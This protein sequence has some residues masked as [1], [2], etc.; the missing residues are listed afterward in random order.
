MKLILR[1]G[2]WFGL[3]LFLVLLPL[4]TAALFRP[5]R[6]SPSIQA[7]IAVAAG[8]VGYTLMAL[9]FAL[10]SR[11]KAAAYRAWSMPPWRTWELKSQ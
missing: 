4:I 10:I 11:T 8:F 7:E 3:Y 6:I 1:G 2:L 9:E 5:A